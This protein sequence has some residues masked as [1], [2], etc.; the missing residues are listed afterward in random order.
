MI[1][2][3]ELTRESASEMSRV[4]DLADSLGLRFENVIRSGSQANVIG[5]Q[6]ET[7][8]FS[9]R[10]DS[11]TYFVQDARYGAGQRGVW[12]ASNDD[13]LDAARGVLERLQ[14]PSSEIADARV[15]KEQ[16]QV[17]ELDRETGKPRV[18]R[19]QQGKVYATF[20]RQIDGIPVWSS[21]VIAG[22][23]RD[24]SLGFLQAH[25]PE[26][27]QAVVA[28]AKRLAARVTGEWTAP[29]HP[30]ATVESVEA[31]VVHS[32]AVAFLMDVYPAI[33]VIYAPIDERM[34]QKATR[35]LDRHG[36]DVPV[37]RQFDLPL[38]PSMDRRAEPKDRG[39]Q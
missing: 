6:S 37:P 35:Y 15:L 39:N 21:T 25:W 20:T 4:R 36:N 23:T 8:L 31:G 33:R 26:I 17:A 1:P 19:P 22:F 32:P 9:Q 34:G 11:R 2:K 3:N 10:L 24:R 30:G 28:E 5:I 18:E 27:P 14:I 7:L 38:E 29:E 12:G 16:T 13:Y